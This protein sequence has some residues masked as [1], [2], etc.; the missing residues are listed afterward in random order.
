MAA[1]QIP[2][3][4][5]GPAATAAVNGRV[6]QG[7]AKARGLA[8][9]PVRHRLGHPSLR[10]PSRA[11][12][13]ADPG[14]SHRSHKIC[15][16]GRRS[17]GRRS[18]QRGVIPRAS[19]QSLLLAMARADGRASL[20][21]LVAEAGETSNVPVPFDTRSTADWCTARLGRPTILR[22]RCSGRT[23]SGERK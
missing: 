18:S 1:H 19:E 9:R 4:T 2:T 5:K 20:T 15:D 11:Q 12:G 16:F 6:A 8:G 17:L 10:G 7:A 23:C 21:R 14:Q 22:C 13:S 3:R